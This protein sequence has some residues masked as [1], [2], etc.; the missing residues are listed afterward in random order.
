MECE[1]HPHLQ[2]VERQRVL[3]EVATIAG[4][5]VLPFEKGEVVWIDINDRKILVPAES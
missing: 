4:D 3:L 2:F 1:E 5:T